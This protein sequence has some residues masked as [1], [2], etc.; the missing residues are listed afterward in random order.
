MTTLVESVPKIRS[1]VTER[2]AKSVRGIKIDNKDGRGIKREAGETRE[3]KRCER[4][5]STVFRLK[6]KNKKAGTVPA[7]RL[8]QMPMER[9]CDQS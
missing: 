8:D 3:V 6:R 1:K 9:V 5:R 7:R 2:V 4:G